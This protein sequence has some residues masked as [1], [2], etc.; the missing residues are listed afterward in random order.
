M[1][2]L[3]LGLNINNNQYI[4]AANSKLPKRGSDKK[5]HRHSHA[6]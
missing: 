5:Q 3:L 4:T 2:W 1:V 6:K